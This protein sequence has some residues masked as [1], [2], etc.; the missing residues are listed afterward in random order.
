MKRIYYVCL[1]FNVIEVFYVII[2][3][4]LMCC[5]DNAGVFFGSNT[6]QIISG[7]LLTPTL[8]LFYK[9]C[10]ICYKKDTPEKGFLLLLLNI[11]YNTFYSIRV[12]KNG[13]LIED[14]K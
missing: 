1:I 11:Y 4:I 9:N 7:I 3:V 6:N 12:L 5:I 14:E 13:W 2:L 8:F 10:V